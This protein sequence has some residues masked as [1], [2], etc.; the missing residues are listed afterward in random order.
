VESKLVYCACDYALSF[1]ICLFIVI[2]VARL[3]DSNLENMFSTS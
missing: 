2:L 1:G 3:S